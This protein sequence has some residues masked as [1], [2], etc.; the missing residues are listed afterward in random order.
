MIDGYPCTAEGTIEV[1]GKWYCEDHAECA[2]SGVDPLTQAAY[3]EENQ[4]VP[5]FEEG[6]EW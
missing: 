6:W 4:V 2:E 1:N 5:A 3:D